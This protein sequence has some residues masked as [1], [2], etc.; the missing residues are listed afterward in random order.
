MGRSALRPYGMRS[1]AAAQMGRSALRPYGMR[2]SILMLFQNPQFLWLFLLLPTLALLWFWRYGRVRWPAL[3]LRLAAVSL[4]VLALAA[5]FQAAPTEVRGPTVILVDQSDS[6]TETGKAA[7]RTEAAQ[8]ARTAGVDAQ[9]LLFGA[10]LVASDE[11]ARSDVQAEPLRLPSPNAS[12]LAGAL[13]AA[14][15]LLP[16]GGNVVLLSDGITTS[17]EALAEAHLAADAGIQIDVLPMLPELLPEVAIIALSAPRTLRTGEEYP[18]DIVVRYQPANLGPQRLEA[19]LQLWDGTLLLGDEAVVL[20]AGDESFTFRHTAEAPGVARLRATLSVA[21]GDTFP[22]NNSA[23]TTVQ[24]VPPPRVLLVESR[25]GTGDPLAAALDRSGIA[26]D[27]ISVETLS[28]RLSDLALYDGMV[29]IDV[30]AADLSLDQMATV[31][32]F[33]RSEGRGLVAVGGRNSFTL[34]AYKDTP[35][36]EALPVLMEPPPRPERSDVSLLLIVD[37]SASMLA[38]LGVSKFDMAKEAAILATENL[39]PTDRI[40]ILAFDTGTLWVVEF[41][42]VGDSAS[43]ANIQERVSRLPSGGGTDIEL[44]LAVGLPALA[45]QTTGVRHA[46]LL[47]DG[48]S[49]SQTPGG[50][51]RLMEAARAQEITLSTIAIGSDADTVL[52]E[53]LAAWGGGR[54]Y[55]AGRPED[56]PRLTLLESE[57]ARADPTVDDPLQAQV[58][59]PHPTIRD[60]A[61]AELPPLDGYVA[62]TPRPG[63]ETVLRSPEE[64]PL[65]AAWQYGLGRSVAWLPSV[66]APWAGQWLAWPEYDRFWAQV[67]RHT[68]PDPE[69]GPLQVRLDP[70]AGG[71]RLTVDVVQPGGAPLDLAVV[72]ARVT[73]PDGTTRSFDVRQSAPGA[74]TQELS[75]AS[76]GGYV[77]SVAVLRDGL[78]Q[79]R[80]VGYV[81]PVAPEYRTGSD[82]AD[83][84]A[85]LAAIAAASGGVELAPAA[86]AIGDEPAGPAAA[87]GPIWPWLVGAALALWVLEIAYRRGLFIR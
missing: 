70:I 40:G 49:F 55:F 58:N 68:L 34:G 6:L 37:R 41:Q 42:D 48:R 67:V 26:S 76:A 78:L 54:Y 32:E 59:L 60:F 15:G 75:L 74:Y 77:V 80:E 36:A 61:E 5:P 79:Q 4:L 23:A 65:L 81:Q 20:V 31:R 64:D 53:Q 11:L 87:P 16:G 71:A 24:V 73:L 82:P 39:Q 3:L 19:R 35:L 8:L 44:S 29:L 18:I 50:Y 43:L 21:E 52:L 62:V 47:T 10:D 17:G 83:G 86:Q 14:R 2:Y 7:L 25:F 69:S 22:D 33:V 66:G 46:V 9:V 85:L 30:P 51:E 57:I 56:I 28:P 84:Q 63:A 12:D 1:F 38:S 45:Q 27:R 13:R 72:N